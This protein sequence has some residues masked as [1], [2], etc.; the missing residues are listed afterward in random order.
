MY[1]FR[2]SMKKETKNLLI[3]IVS[4]IIFAPLAVFY[5]ERVRIPWAVSELLNPNDRYGYK[6]AVEVISYGEKV[7]PILVE[8]SK[9]FEIVNV[10]NSQ[11][12]AWV[13]G[14]LKS[15]YS[16]KIARDLFSR[17]DK[18]TMLAGA[19]ALARLDKLPEGTPPE[20]IVDALVNPVSDTTESFL[21]RTTADLAADALRAYDDKVV[22]KYFSQSVANYNNLFSVSERLLKSGERESIP[23]L[24]LLLERCPYGC[25]RYAAK[26]LYFEEPTVMEI[27]INRLPLSKP[28]IER[29]FHTEVQNILSDLSGRK[30]GLLR[31]PWVQWWNTSKESWK[32]PERFRDPAYYKVTDG[33]AERDHSGVYLSFGILFLVSLLISVLL[34]RAVEPIRK[35]LNMARAK[36]EETIATNKIYA[37][38]WSRGLA[39]VL[40]TLILLPLLFG[41]VYFIFYSREVSIIM[42]VI[43]MSIY[44]AYNIYFHAKYGATLGKMLCKIHLA[45][46]D[47]KPIET[48]RAFYRHA[49]DLMLAFVSLVG[50]VFILL[51]I[52]ESFFGHLGFK[53]SLVKLNEFEVLESYWSAFA[54]DAAMIWILSELVIMQCNKKR[55][56]LH[57][58]IA[59]TVVV[60]DNP[61]D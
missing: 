58:Y 51:Y 45:T 6:N 57:D 29:P 55:R 32:I 41:P 25:Y 22:I 15:E 26:L 7:L 35:K 9:N 18:W 37:G 3:A 30:L 38:V 59:G 39:G 27:L 52:E 1:I 13:L 31:E 11:R 21:Q 54:N 49:I 56:A 42:L 43:Q 46:V 23:G 2:G 53:V 44:P 33:E 47:L 19:A 16:E 10:N 17:A 8:K 60:Y 28:E 20:K 34:L 5:H 12:I 40:D 61:E 50:R 36:D 14:D 24:R 4:L 48:W